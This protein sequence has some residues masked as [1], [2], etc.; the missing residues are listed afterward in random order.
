[1][2]WQTGEGSVPPSE[3]SRTSLTRPSREVE[4]VEDPDATCNLCPCSLG[5]DCVAD[6]EATKS[7]GTKG[8]T[9]DQGDV[10]FKTSKLTPFVRLNCPN[11]LFFLLSTC[12]L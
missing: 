10:S 12:R 9:D 6:D 5:D 8:S 4:L 11:P 3:L 1:M 2:D 7:V